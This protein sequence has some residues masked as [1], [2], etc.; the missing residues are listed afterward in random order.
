VSVNKI[1][2]TSAETGNG[3]LDKV[4]NNLPYRETKICVFDQLDFNTFQ[5]QLAM[6]KTQPL[7]FASDF[8]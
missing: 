3:L 7:E 8:Q 5:H 6:S 1:E 2:Y 4:C